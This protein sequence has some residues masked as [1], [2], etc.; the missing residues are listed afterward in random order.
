[1]GHRS[2]A[3][4]SS[5]K[6]NHIPLYARISLVAFLCCLGLLVLFIVSAQTLSRHELAEQVYYLVLV[7]V[8]ATVAV[9]L[10]GVIPSS[11]T[12][13]GKV[14]GGTLRASGAVVGAALVVV[15]GYYFKPRGFTFPLTVYVYGPGG[16][17][18]IVL[19]NSGHVA[20]QVGPQVQRELVGENGEAYF[21]AIPTNFRG[22]E[23]P[24]WIESDEFEVVDAGKNQRLETPA[25]NLT[26]RAKVKRYK[27]AGI[28]SDK[29]GNP[30]GAVRVSLPDYKAE[31]ITSNDGRY[32]MGVADTNQRMVTL[33]A[34]KKG[35]TT[36]RLSPT[37]GDSGFNFSLQR[38]P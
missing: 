15:G 12:Y 29:R 5:S 36:V 25:L 37:L 7:S 22:Q 38:E 17:S 20:I 31:S 6:P 4:A 19:R 3:P 35:Y 23:V 34:W 8:G 1:M 2:A 9:F 27:I 18:D 30:I 33:I 24:V 11:A 32:E 21:P 16:P 13:K 10:F 28:I 26:V 14:L